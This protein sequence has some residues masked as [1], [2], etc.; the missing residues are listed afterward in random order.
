MTDSSAIG[1]RLFRFDV[2]ADSHLEPERPGE[3]VPRSNRRFAAV[4]D[5]IN[6]DPGD[7]VLHLGDVVHPLPGVAESADA[8]Q[9]ARTLLSRLGG[10]LHVTPGNHD[11]GDKPHKLVPAAIV[12]PEWLHC[13][14]EGFGPHWRMFDHRDC[15]FVLINDILFNSGLREEA[16][17]EAWL[18]EVLADAPGRIFLATHYPLFLRAPDEGPLYDNVDEPARGRI[19][20]LARE[21]GIEAI[22]SGHVHIWL[23][24]RLER[25]DL[26]G[27]PSTAF[28]RRDY[29]EMFRVGPRA[30]AGREDPDKVGWVRVDIHTGGHVC[31][32][33]R[34]G[35]GT[36]PHAAPPSGKAG[37]WS[38]LGVS[39][40]HP[41]CETVELP[42]NPPTDAFVRKRV[43]NDYPA[44]ALSELGLRDLRVPVEDL[45]EPN[46][47]DC[48]ALLAE[49]GFRFT[50]FTPGLPSAQVLAALAESELVDTLEIVLTADSMEATV[51]SAGPVLTGAG[52]RLQ[53]TPLRPPDPGDAGRAG[54]HEI[55]YGFD[56]DAAAIA[57]ELHG[58]SSGSLSLVAGIEV[59]LCA[60]DAA[61]HETLD[62]LSGTHG[63]GAAVMLTWRPE[64]KDDTATDDAAL[65][66]EIERVA[67]IATARQGSGVRIFLDTLMA[68]DRSYHVRAG[69]IDRRANLTAAGR[70]VQR[71]ALRSRPAP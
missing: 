29:S 5:A 2:I 61:L 48:M 51:A 44:L 50:V 53:I 45:T 26:Y 28:V 16:E 18:A 14:A 7:F 65:A 17:Q 52:V 13:F 39:L 15:R 20:A 47:R 30:E 12:Q 22:F 49:A 67:A 1:D 24:N 40:R 62:R 71:A 56:P 34:L 43:R 68:F 32:V 70:A 35:E 41:W 9:T 58:L 54:R 19:L 63:I 25:T 69:L 6:A 57:A 66:R 60:F 4:T 55:R 31:R 64:D 59:P 36:A 42:F 3:P 23:H 8:R 46:V 38:G 27:I 21:H 10:P 11:I 37:E 33:M